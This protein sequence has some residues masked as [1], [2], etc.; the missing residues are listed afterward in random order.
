M[1][2]ERE[3][4]LTLRHHLLSDKKKEEFVYKME[5]EGFSS[6]IVLRLWTIQLDV[7]MDIQVKASNVSRVSPTH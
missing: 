6:N 7:N 2:T 3:N 4:K 5:V 1:P